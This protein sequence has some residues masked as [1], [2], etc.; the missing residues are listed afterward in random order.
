MTAN[1]RNLKRVRVHL[2]ESQSQNS[3]TNFVP[4]VTSPEKRKRKRTL[5]EEDSGAS[6]LSQP[7]AEEFSPEE[8]AEFDLFAS[9]A[10]V[11]S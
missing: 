5:D 3:Q 4:P 11:S 6:K 9:A 2:I 10:K 1:P 8:Q 7:A